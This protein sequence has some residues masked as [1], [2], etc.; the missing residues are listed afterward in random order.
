MKKIAILAF[1]LSLAIV[2]C[3]KEKEEE[4]VVEEEVVVEQ[5]PTISIVNDSTKV[6]WTAYKTTEKVAVGG[7]FT[8]INLTE[9]RTGTTPEEVL[10][11]AKFSIPVNSVFTDNEERDGKLI[12]FFFSALENTELISGKIHFSDGV[13]VLAITLNGQTN[14]VVMN[15]NFSNNLYTFDGVI[16]LEDFGAKAAVESL[17]KACFDLHKGTD[18]VS[19]TWSEVAIKGSVLFE[20]SEAIL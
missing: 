6:S 1:A 15:G 8:K 5:T 17:N 18:G 3:K 20:D 10:E 7:S 11:E 4:K 14:E 9:T 16:N 12:K 2:S 19:K 13:P